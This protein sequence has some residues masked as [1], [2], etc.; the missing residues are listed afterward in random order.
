MLTVGDELF[1]EV[2]HIH[3]PV[4]ANFDF[5]RTKSQVGTAEWKAEIF[6][7]K[8]GPQRLN[9]RKDQVLMQGI[10][11]QQMASI[12][13]RQRIPLVF[14][15]GMTEAGRRGMFHERQQTEGIR[16]TDIAVLALRSFFV[17]PSLHI[18]ETT[19]ASPVMTGIDATVSIHFQ[20]KSI[21]APFGKQ[22][23]AFC[24]RMITPDR[25]A[26]TV[27]CRRIGFSAVFQM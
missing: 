27:N 9:F 20:A 10:H 2:G 26:F 3:A 12:F 8:R 17:I 22:F 7:L 25:G 19:R 16:V 6:S 13:F 11:R 24:F 14:H 21:T 18:I 5:N 1:I 23:V 4:R 15:Q